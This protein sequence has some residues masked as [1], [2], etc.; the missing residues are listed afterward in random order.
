MEFKILKYPLHNKISEDAFSYLIARRG[1]R[2]FI[3]RMSPGGGHFDVVHHQPHQRVSV[4]SGRIKHEHVGASARD[5]DGGRVFIVR[6][7]NIRQYV[8][9]LNI[10]IVAEGPQG[11]VS[12]E[13]GKMMVYN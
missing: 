2:V 6:A 5:P 12:T 7:S 10:E 3:S 8:V 11:L 9:K 13:K 4:A 1:I